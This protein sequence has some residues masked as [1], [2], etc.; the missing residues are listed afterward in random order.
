M[1]KRELQER[2]L[3]Y[4]RV[5]RRI[6]E[7]AGAAQCHDDYVAAKGFTMAA[8]DALGLAVTAQRPP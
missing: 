2:L 3:E 8:I 7:V 4:E 6:A 1:T 5:F